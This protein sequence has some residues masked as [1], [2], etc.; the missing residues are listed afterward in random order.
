[1]VFNRDGPLAGV[2]NRVAFQW[3][4][5]S[6]GSICTYLICGGVYVYHEAFGVA[7]DPLL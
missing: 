3:D 2:R 5:I 6:W 7:G 1:M 4:V